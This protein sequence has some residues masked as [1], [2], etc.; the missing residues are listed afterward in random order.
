MKSKFNNKFTFFSAN[1]NA[2]VNIKSILN[3]FLI[4]IIIVLNI[5]LINVLY[6]D[7][8]VSNSNTI[9]ENFDVEKYVDICKNKKTNFYDL[10][11]SKL[12]TPINVNSNSDC[13]LLCAQGNCE[14]FL[15]TDISNSTMKKCLLFNDISGSY[16]ISLTLNCE[17]NILPQDDYGVYNGYGFVNKHYFKDN[18]S[19]FHYIDRYLEETKYIIDDLSYINYLNGKAVSLDLTNS[20][21]KN[22]YDFLEYEKIQA[23]NTVLN[24]IND[25]NNRVFFNS[26][27]ILFTDLLN[28]SLS[29][30]EI[31]A[32]ILLT[33]KRDLSFINLINNSISTNNNSE[34]LNNK[35]NT[36][37]TNYNSINS[38]YLILFVIMV[39]TI[40]LLILYTANI[41][42]ELL[43]FSYF[44]LIILLILF[45][46]NIVKI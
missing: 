43:L 16:D 20:N 19:G 12:S 6:Y 9:K 14:I 36:L 40:V 5:Y 41:I 22:F 4:I 25:V 11:T 7:S 2:N 46:N 42:S 28:S 13:E 23:Y 33:P 39:L 30:N 3:I 27:N 26:K 32:N 35:Q 31:S 21:N 8:F 37:L 29:H 15:L 34:I 24:I 18:N 17:S 44:I 38:I 10:T 1:A 45:I